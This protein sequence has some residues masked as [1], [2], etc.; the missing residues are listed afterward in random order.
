[1][2]DVFTRAELARPSSVLKLKRGVC[3]IDVYANVNAIDGHL[4]GAYF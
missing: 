4:L 2:L 1:M 3:W